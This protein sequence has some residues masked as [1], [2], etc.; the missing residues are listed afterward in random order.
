[1]SLTLSFSA[2]RLPAS[3]DPI[4][5]VLALD[6]RSERLVGHTEAQRQ[7]AAPAWRKTLTVAPPAVLKFAVFDAANLPG[8]AADGADAGGGGS[9]LDRLLRRGRS[10]SAENS[11]VSALTAARGTAL[12]SD[13]LVGAVVVDLAQLGHVQRHFVAQ[14]LQLRHPFDAEIDK[15]L[16]R[17]GAH[18]AVTAA[19]ADCEPP[20]V[21]PS[22]ALTA[23]APLTGGPSCALP[24]PSAY[25]LLCRGCVFLKFPFSSSARP[26][27]RLVFFSRHP[28]SPTQLLA[29]EHPLYDPLTD[30]SPANPLF[31]L[32]LLYWCSPGRRRCSAERCLPLHAITALYEQCQ[33]PAFAALLREEERERQS[34]LS[35]RPRPSLS[36]SFSVVSRE[37]SLDLVADSREVRDAFLFA[38]HS[39][40]VQRGRLWYD[41]AA[42]HSG[43]RH[44][45]RRLANERHAERFVCASL[46]ANHLPLQPGDSDSHVR[47]VLSRTTRAVGD[48]ADGD[49]G[50]AALRRQS[51][52]G[53][54]IGQS[55]WAPLDDALTFLTA[56]FLPLPD[57]ASACE[58]HMHLYDPQH[59]LLARC[60]FLSALLLHAQLDIPLPLRHDLSSVD[61]LLTY[62]R[63]CAVLRV[64]GLAGPEVA[65][66][67]L[68]DVMAMLHAQ[69]SYDPSLP[70]L[71]LSFMLRGEACTYLPQP[72][73]VLTPSVLLYHADSDALTVGGQ[74]LP[75]SSLVSVQREL[76]P[77]SGLSAAVYAVHPEKRINSKRMLVLDTA[78]EGEHL[79]EMRS[80]L[81]ADAWVCGL[82]QMMRKKRGAAE[83]DSGSARLQLEAEPLDWKRFGG[84]RQGEDDDA[85]DEA[86]D[87]DGAGDGGGAGRAATLAVN[88]AYEN[89][90]ALSPT[91]WTF[92]RAPSAQQRADWH[93]AD[94]ESELRVSRP[95]LALSAFA[96]A[97][98]LQD[99]DWDCREDA[100]NADGESAGVDLADGHL[101]V[102]DAERSRGSSSAPSVQSPDFHSRSSS[103]SSVYEPE[104]HLRSPSHSTNSAAG[105]EQQSADADSQPV[106]V[107]E[108]APPVP[109]QP[110]DVPD[111]PPLADSGV[112][113]APPLTVPTTAGD[114]GDAGQG[115]GAR[116]KRFHWDVPGSDV[117]VSGTIFSTFDAALDAESLEQ[118]IHLFS[119][120]PL[121]RPSPDED[122]AATAKAAGRA[123]LVELL[124]PRRG[125]NLAIALRGFKLPVPAIARALLTCDLTVLTLERVQTLLTV[126]PDAR[127]VKAV[128]AYAGDE[129]LLGVAERYVREVARVPR[130]ATRL[131]LLLFTHTYAD[132]FANLHAQCAL[133]TRAC[134]ALRGS[135][136]LARA[137]QLVLS[138]G[139]ALNAR[140]E[141]AFRLATLDRLHALKA[142][143][144]SAFSLLDFVVERCIAQAQTDECV[145]PQSG[146]AFL[147]ALVHSRLH[148]AAKCDWAALCADVRTLQ[149]QLVLVRR[150]HDREDMRAAANQSFYHHLH[151]FLTA[152][153]P[154]AAQLEA[155]RRSTGELLESTLRFFG[156]VADVG[157]VGAFF[158]LIDRFTANFAVSEGR[159]WSR[160]AAEL[161]R[162]DLE[163]RKRAWKDEQRARAEER[164]ARQKDTA[165]V[166]AGAHFVYEQRGAGVEDED[167]E[168]EMAE[169]DSA[170]SSAATSAAASPVLTAHFASPP[171][172]FDVGK[173]QP[174]S[175][176]A[177]LSAA[178]A[179]DVQR[180][181][182]IGESGHLR[183]PQAPSMSLS[184]EHLTY[185]SR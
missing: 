109:A 102:E 150:E 55:E 10:S 136:R 177:A 108:E 185:Q 181:D 145:P 43:R 138:V 101:T 48:D 179:K 104:F 127:E 18:L 126:H 143:G 3:L 182:G 121:P 131:Q 12:N 78:D 133:L 168:E 71:S 132:A 87:E 14:R 39:I 73:L 129:A 94:E 40:L 44:D 149:E 74:E 88:D 96:V 4:L 144:G 92:A 47:L 67:D 117:D 57:A 157:S 165:A 124:E 31:P 118:L 139:N 153:I 173:T 154:Q 103:F 66:G 42:P 82:R 119:A 84:A 58:Y 100:L 122:A 151:A 79:V 22:P 20:P 171:A 113:E 62:S 65:R 93:S 19:P 140:R 5:C 52:R 183:W 60:G 155:L 184:S 68:L 8:A 98:G 9:L 135:A 33:T 176:A 160:R 59:R 174:H 72:S 85:A 51:E 162:A 56:F 75:L 110:I 164:R 111:A 37:R 30:S 35:K 178:D 152:A 53:E 46:S 41:D 106:A 36:C 27:R 130:C 11:A 24:F 61:A 89:D 112:P 159:W 50:A 77:S 7:T 134:D 97:D 70:Y 28:L 25:R 123:G 125:Q 2:R 115:A 29:Q 180:A 16:Q 49:E 137:L 142:R 64:T 95:L 170:A 167:E 114:S 172:G 86:G 63:S 99:G 91:P 163:Q 6:G 120:A 38:L 23:S 34:A 69:P 175:I 1:M 107:A 80:V 158:A 105:E 141:S 15:R 116:L 146:D 128:K 161:R 32:G 148:D 45:E 147:A 156:E 17:L 13:D 76:R 21:Q 169:N 83:D 166:A 26:Q 54:V 81:S 90:G